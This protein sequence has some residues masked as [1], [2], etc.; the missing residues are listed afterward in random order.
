MR[1]QATPAARVPGEIRRD[2]V[3]SLD[4][5]RQRLRIGSKGIRTMREAGLPVRYAGRA[6]FVAGTDFARFVATLPTNRDATGTE[7]GAET[8]GLGGQRYAH[9]PT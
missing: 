7:T 4:E 8:P 5:I 2:S 9:H 6:A 3:Y 1:K